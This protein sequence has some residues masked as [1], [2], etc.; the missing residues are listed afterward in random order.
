MTWKQSNSIMTIF[1]ELNKNTK[2]IKKFNEITLSGELP[3]LSFN[4]KKELFR[5]TYQS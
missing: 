5:R 2:K 3:V 4:K 1:C